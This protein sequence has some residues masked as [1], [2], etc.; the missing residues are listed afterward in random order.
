MDEWKPQIRQMLGKT[1]MQ[2]DARKA[3]SCGNKA[4]RTPASPTVSIATY[5]SSSAGASHENGAAYRTTPQKHPKAA[6]SSASTIFPPSFRSR[7][8]GAIAT[9]SRQ[10]ST[11]SLD[12][13]GKSAIVQ[14]LNQV[15][16]TSASKRR[17]GVATPNFSSAA[18][19]P[20][21]P[22]AP[23]NID[24]E[25]Q[26]T[27]T[28]P[29]TSLVQW[30]YVLNLD[31]S[32]SSPFD[33]WL[34]GLYKSKPWTSGPLCKLQIRWEEE[35][36]Y[37]KGKI[38]QKFEAFLKTWDKTL[39]SMRAFVEKNVPLTLWIASTKALTNKTRGDGL[40][41]YRTLY[42]LH[43]ATNNDPNWYENL[44]PD[45]NIP[46]SREA[47]VAFLR[48]LESSMGEGTTRPYL[49]DYQKDYSVQAKWKAGE[50][51]NKI[52]EY[53]SSGLNTKPSFK[54]SYNL[55]GGEAT[56]EAVYYS[57]LNIKGTYFRLHQLGSEESGCANFARYYC[58]IHHAKFRNSV[59]SDLR[60]L[61]LV[62]IFAHQRFVVYD[63]SHFFPADIADNFRSDVNIDLIFEELVRGICK[64]VQS[65]PP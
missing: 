33:R 26:I 12:R 19:G 63:G 35:M 24:E 31:P 13:T 15:E 55:W 30:D 52:E 57:P 51:A 25:V 36:G 45:L 43:N 18:S 46:E 41:F 47:F 61:D 62:E 32:K 49:S 38:V 39:E 53:Y 37:R 8:S 22:A 44:D 23:E 64:Y 7:S 40:C 50:A 65:N 56:A 54:L 3:S 16:V 11:N 6:S 14:L 27:E 10:P 42:Q 34:F 48:L 20:V 1:K 4:P 2:M 28:G 29:G 17:A 58:C 9:S 60:Y 59:A 21:A 5:F